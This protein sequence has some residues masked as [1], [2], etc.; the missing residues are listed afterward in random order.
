[1]KGRELPRF[2]RLKSEFAQAPSATVGHFRLKLL[3]LRETTLDRSWRP[4]A[5]GQDN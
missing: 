3:H 5:R 2:F 4:L 1:M